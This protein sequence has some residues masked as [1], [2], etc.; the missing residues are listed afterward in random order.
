MG[1]QLLNI[2]NNFSWHFATTHHFK[3]I[4]IG[5]NIYKILFLELCLYLYAF[6]K[7][8]K[9]YSQQSMVLF[10]SRY[11]KVKVEHYLLFMFRP[12]KISW[13]VWEIKYIFLHYLPVI[14]LIQPSSKQIICF[15]F[16]KQNSVLPIVFYVPWFWCLTKIEIHLKECGK[17]EI[18][19]IP[20]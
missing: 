20:F 19:I 16:R 11:V 18:W 9:Y 5:K 1:H 15:D 7:K 4:T 10:W 6:A 13:A 14:Y 3:K 8:Y 12:P 17:I 2:E